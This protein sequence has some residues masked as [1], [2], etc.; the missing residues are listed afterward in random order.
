MQDGRDNQGA[1]T[2]CVD[3]STY[4]LRSIE[5]PENYRIGDT[6]TLLYLPGRTNLARQTEYLAFD[7]IWLCGGLLCLAVSL[8]GERLIRRLR[9]VLNPLFAKGIH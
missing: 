1:L 6:Q 4:Y 8:L 7:S 2:Y 5:R 9:G 3:G